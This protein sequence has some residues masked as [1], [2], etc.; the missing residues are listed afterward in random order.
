MA[1]QRIIVATDGSSLGNPGPAGWAWYAS[2]T[3]WQAGGIDRAT[4]QAAELH[5]VMSALAAIP[6]SAPLHVRTDSQY[7]LKA[8]S[9]WMP[10]WKA[11]QWRKADGKPVLNLPL[12]QRID[13]LLGARAHP[14]TWQWVRGHAGDPLNEAADARCTAAARAV[15]VRGVVRSGPGWPGARCAGCGQSPVACRCLA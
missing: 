5:A 6:D 11:N 2:A 1:S 8:C 14:V 3:S 15:R 7:A 12:L 10:R 13:E 4:N 9:Q